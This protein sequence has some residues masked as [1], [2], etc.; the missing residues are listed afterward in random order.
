MKRNPYV[1]ID[2]YDIETR[3]QPRKI[4][5]IS[6]TEED[7]RKYPD[8]YTAYDRFSKLTGLSKD[9][10]IL[11]N[12]T[13][14]ALRIAMQVLK[15]VKNIKTVITEIPTWGLAD[16]IAYQCN[17]EKSYKLDYIYRE[18]KFHLFYP[19][20]EFIDEPYNNMILYK[21]NKMNNLFVHEDEDE[22]KSKNNT[23]YTIH[24][25][26]YTPFDAVDKELDEHNIIIG[27]FSK[28]FGCGIRLG[29]V[30]FN[31]EYFDMMNI[32]REEYISPIACESLKYLLDRYG[33]I[34]NCNNI[35]K[36]EAFRK[37]ESEKLFE[38]TFKDHIICSTP[39]YYTMDIYVGNVGLVSK[40]FEVEGKD[41]YRLGRFLKED[42]NGYFVFKNAFTNI[43]QYYN[44]NGNNSL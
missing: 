42:P 21:T 1:K 5:N 36:E 13:E 41:F 18:G 7:I 2:E 11:T 37:Y 19:G 16:V 38:E 27:S 14:N 44:L 34:K 30:I 33:N 40:R 6:I 3:N 23:I 17:F 20:L 4:I 24:D 43:N 39:Y 10:F 22:Y 32:Y 31:K 12:G 8:M 26:T 15:R 35:Y 28:V 9:S 29:F 25:Y